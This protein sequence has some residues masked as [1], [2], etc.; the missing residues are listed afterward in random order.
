MRCSVNQ[1]RYG[2][3]RTTADV[4]DKAVAIDNQK[5]SYIFTLSLSRRKGYPTGGLC[6][7]AQGQG[8]G[9]ERSEAKWSPPVGYPFLRLR[10]TKMAF[11]ARLPVSL[12]FHVQ[13]FAAAPHKKSHAERKRFAYR[14]I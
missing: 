7:P 1:E 2:R 9:P 3:K 10:V 14:Q 13:D 11:C 12:L 6:T 8:E 4:P 5:D